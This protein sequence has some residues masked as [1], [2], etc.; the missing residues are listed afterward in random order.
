MAHHE[1]NQLILWLTMK[2][3]NLYYGSPQSRSN[4]IMAQDE[5]DQFVRELRSTT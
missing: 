5:A 4:F 2:Q 3:T 1:A